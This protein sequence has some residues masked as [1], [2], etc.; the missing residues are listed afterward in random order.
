MNLWCSGLA[1]RMVVF[2]A[3]CSAVVM[4]SPEFERFEFLRPCRHLVGLMWRLLATP[5]G[6]LPSSSSAACTRTIGGGG[7]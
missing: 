4:A 1:G 5:M 7:W 2:V 6:A 3:T